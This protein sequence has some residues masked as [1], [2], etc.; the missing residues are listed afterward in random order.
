MIRKTGTLAAAATLLL[1]GAATQAQADIITYDLTDS[2]HARYADGGFYKKVGGNTGF[3]VYSFDAPGAKAQLSYDEDRGVVRVFGKGV[4]RNTGQLSDF[5]LRYEDVQRE[6]N[7]LKLQDMSQ[8][9]SFGGTNTNGKGFNLTLGDTL[10][11]DGWLVDTSTGRHFGDFHF[12]GVKAPDGGGGVPAPAPLGL[13]AMA[14]LFGL[15]RR[16]RRG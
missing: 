2:P 8:I 14:A 16:R 13:L 7:T 10:R 5:A 12:A 15:A 1:A 4:N 6:G 9:G 11:G 3:E